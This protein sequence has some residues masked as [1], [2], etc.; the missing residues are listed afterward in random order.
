MLKLTDQ[1]EILMCDALSVVPQV[2][3]MTV[4][5]IQDMQNMPNRKDVKS[6]D[7][8][9]YEYISKTLKEKYP[10]ATILGEKD[11]D[12]LTSE[13]LNS[14]LKFIVEPVAN[15][16][17]DTLTR[18]CSMSIGIVVGDELIGGIVYDMLNERVYFAMQGKGASV[19]D[20]R[21][22]FLAPYLCEKYNTPYS[23]DNLAHLHP[24]F[25][26]STS[27]ED[28]VVAFNIPFNQEGYLATDSMLRT[29]FEKSAKTM[30]SG[31]VCM[32]ILRTAA[33][34]KYRKIDAADAMFNMDATPYNIAGATCI[35][36]EMGGDV[37]DLEDGKS[38]TTAELTN[39]ERRIKVAASCDENLRKELVSA[40]SKSI[41]REQGKA[42]QMRV[43]QTKR[44]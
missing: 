15:T 11:A 2:K 40:Y 34:P 28:S 3:A 35:I 27:L 41:G 4:A 33:G 9:T 5:Y 10:K 19:T 12:N 7:E 22:I 32:A 20:P 37:V 21:S 25:R 29:L 6:I 16:C 14:P 44:A 17:D 30:V 26:E 38:I 1:K 42:L 31:P 36:R 18:S 13:E 8:I 39:P 43:M 24:Y 23:L